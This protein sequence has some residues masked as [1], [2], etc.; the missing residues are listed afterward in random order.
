MCLLCIWWRHLNVKIDIRYIKANI[1]G[2]WMSD[3]EWMTGIMLKFHNFTRQKWI[4]KY[5]KLI[6]IMSAMASQITSRTIVYST[7]YSGVDQRK[8]QSFSALAFVRGIHRNRWIPRTQG[9]YSWPWVAREMFPFDDVIMRCENSTPTVFLGTS[10]HWNT[11]LLAIC[12]RNLLDPL[13]KGV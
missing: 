11:A 2:N 4:K 3:R 1:N 10:W 8:H 9:Q 5:H 12:N 6:V 7:I 13:T